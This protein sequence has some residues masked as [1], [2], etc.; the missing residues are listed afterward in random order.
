MVLN[1]F[2]P[3]PDTYSLNEDQLV[4]D[5]RVRGNP[6]PEI[7]WMK[8]T[9]MITNDEKYQQFD[10]G[11]GYCKLI[12]RSP[13]EKDS[14][15][16]ICK[17]E[18]A[19]GTDKM[20]HVVEFKGRERFILEK[21]HGFFHRDPNKP[22]LTNILGDHMVPAGGTL[23]LQAEF[24]PTPSPV[25]VQWLKNKSLLPAAP[26]V[27]TFVDRGVFTLAIEKA[28]K[29]DS[30]TYTCRASNAF[31]RL[32]SNANVHIVAPVVKGGKPALFLSRPENEMKIAV[33]DPFSISFRVQGDPKP[34]CNK[35]F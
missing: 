15:A 16:Y 34:K 27:R 7:S 1:I 19:V 6:R 21:A 25:E 5:C 24:G 10:Q 30:G 28:T 18:N 4:L 23:A 9:D 22:H 14:G 35:L 26:N 11:D 12:V 29:E 31:G 17:A 33:H 8:D 3:I 32:E 2:L 20:S 13:T